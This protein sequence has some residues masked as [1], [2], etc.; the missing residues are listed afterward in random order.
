[1]YTISASVVPAIMGRD[2]YTDLVNAW[3]RVTKRA[4]QEEQ[5]E[6]A[7]I[8]EVLEQYAIEWLTR[9]T[10]LSVSATQV[11]TDKTINDAWKLYARI[12]AV[13]SDGTPIEI[14]STREYSGRVPDTWYL[15]IQTQLLTTGRDQ[16]MLVVVSRADAV[17]TLEIVEAD[18]ECQRAI[19]EQCDAFVREYIVTDTP[20]PASSTWSAASLVSVLGPSAEET[21]LPASTYIT[22]AEL[23][24]KA[25]KLKEEAEQYEQQ[26][27]EILARVI[28]TERAQKVVYSGRTVAYVVAPKERETVDVNR[29]RTLAPGIYEQCRK[30]SPVKPYVRW[31]L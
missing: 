31:M 12:D 28:S 17:T 25:K 7:R 20:P 30:I 10:G 21:E 2:P 16:A 1:M 4:P 14:K 8:G 29:L 3:L 23:R 9:T 24:E 22:V 19:I 5:S 13:A 18:V 11:H 6:A 26:A 27:N 15:Q